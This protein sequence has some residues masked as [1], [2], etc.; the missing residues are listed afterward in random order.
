M[1]WREIRVSGKESLK[2][3]KRAGREGLLPLAAKRPD[4]KAGTL[5]KGKE[6]NP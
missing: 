4:P 1:L 6:D 3:G 2:E 5:G